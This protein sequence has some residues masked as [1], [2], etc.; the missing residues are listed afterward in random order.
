M[1]D[2]LFNRGLKGADVVSENT[3]RLVI[4]VMILVVIAALALLIGTGLDGSASFLGTT[5]N[6]ITDVAIGGNSIGGFTNP[7]NTGDNV[8]ANAYG[9]IFPQP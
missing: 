8:L 5:E 2:F 7:F 3:E 1:F 6:G 4:A 9:A